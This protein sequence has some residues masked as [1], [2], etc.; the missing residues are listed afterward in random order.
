[1]LITKMAL[2]NLFRHKRRTLFTGLTIMGGF[3]LSSLSLG[4]AEGSYGNIIK[5][6]IRASTGNIQ[7]HKKGYLDN[8]SIYKTI[9]NPENLEREI[10]KMS[11]VKSISPRIYFPA[12]IFS[13]NRTNATRIIGIDPE[14]EKK[15]TTIGKRISEGKFLSQTPENEIMLGATV[16]KIIKAKT[17]DEVSIVSQAYDG[18]M[19]DGNFEVVAVMRDENSQD[20]LN[21]YMNISRVQEF[22]YMGDS[23]HELAIM[24]EYDDKSRETAKLI[25]EKISDTSLEAEPWQAVKKDFY[26]AMQADKKGNNVSIIIVMVIVAIGVLNTV[27]MS[28]LERTREFGVLKALGTKPFH[29]LKLIIYETAFLT[30]FSL[31]VGTVIAFL[32]NY[33]FEA[34]GIK[35]SKEIHYGGLIF[36]KISSTLEFKIFLIPALVTFITAVT[37]SIFPAV[38]AARIT[39]VKA[40]RD[41]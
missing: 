30:F 38:R 10:L 35:M 5:A 2:R 40:M 39:P 24:L 33:Y 37:V 9:N 31:A 41:F 32:L 18:S 17:G 8:P 36:D 7:I 12:L 20:S 34:Y 29:I 1:M 27:L 19:A 28:V 16:A 22:F 25:N 13:G 4:I 26:R 14:K 6:F 21:S 11:Q 23:I 15:T 3:V